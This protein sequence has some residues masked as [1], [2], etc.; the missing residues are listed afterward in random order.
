MGARQYKSTSEVQQLDAGINANVG[1]IVLT[2]NSTYHPATL[3]SPPY[4]LVLDPDTS[5]EEIVT[6]TS[7]VSDNVLNVTRGED[8][9]GKIDHSAGVL[10]KHMVTARDL[11][12]PQNHIYATTGIHGLANGVAPAPTVN[13]TFIGTVTL[14]NGTVTSA[15]ILDGTIV[16]SD[17]N[18]SA[19]IAT[20]KL[21]GTTSTLALGTNAS[22][23]TANSL[24]ISA[25]EISY[26]DGVAS[27]IQTQITAKPTLSYEGTVVN[28]NIFVQAVQPTAVNVGDIWIDY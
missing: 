6:V 21:D 24:T 26:L 28:R 12:E 19:A 17:I 14:P 11:Q 13:P 22:A 7:K 23:I 16:N 8:G 27:P 1:Q 2:N 5:K 10:V 15:M 20:S 3:P 4:S 18:A 9:T 25:T